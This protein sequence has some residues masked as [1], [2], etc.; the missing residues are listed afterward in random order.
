M[1]TALLHQAKIIFAST[2]IAEGRTEGKKRKMDRWERFR[3]NPEDN[4][5]GHC[6]TKQKMT[7]RTGS[8][9]ES[10]GIIKKKQKE[11]KNKI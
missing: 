8:K 1:Y 5:Q 3:K 11:E 6:T 2:C 10:N 4:N 7:Q 9:C